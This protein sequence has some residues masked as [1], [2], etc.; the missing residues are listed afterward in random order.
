MELETL[1]NGLS[2]NANPDHVPDQADEGAIHSQ[3]TILV[4]SVLDEDRSYQV[5]GEPVTIGSGKD[6]DI[7]LAAAPG[8][9]QEHARMWWRD[10][11]LML[12][13]L[14][15]NQVTVVSGRHIIWT[16][17]RDGDEAAIGPYLL[18]IAL[19]REEYQQQ[20]TVLADEQQDD[21]YSKLPLIRVG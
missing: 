21:A 4:T 10:G 12:H 17:L 15:P 18:R 6:C 13:H 19:Q 20:D 3:A 8:V 5:N 9:Y 14:A 11:R 16:T 7:K 2:N 1:D